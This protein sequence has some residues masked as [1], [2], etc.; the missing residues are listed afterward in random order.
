MYICGL[1]LS[2][3]KD[4]LFSTGVEETA[5]EGFPGDDEW[6]HA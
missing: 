5:Y 4:Y 6:F 2:N 3:Y 1:V